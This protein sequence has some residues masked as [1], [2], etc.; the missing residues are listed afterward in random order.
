MKNSINQVGF[1]L[2]KITTEQFA[3]LDVDIDKTKEIGLNTQIGFGLDKKNK[4]FIVT[5]LFKFLQESNPFLIIEVA[6]HFRISNQ[7]WDS[8]L[9]SNDKSITFSKDFASHLLVITVGTTRGVLHAKTENT[10]FNE[11]L[12]PTVNVNSLI[13]EDI[14]LELSS[15]TE[16]A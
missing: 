14:R 6:C 13:K 3:M 10:K 5:A 1:S 2:S 7:A 16:T 15:P 4:L 12:L 9:S 11:F 8:I